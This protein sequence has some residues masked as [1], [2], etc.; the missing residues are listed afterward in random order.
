MQRIKWGL[1]TSGLNGTYLAMMGMDTPEDRAGIPN[2]PVRVCGLLMRNLLGYPQAGKL[3]AR[4]RQLRQDLQEGVTACHSMRCRG[5]ARG[6]GTQ[7]LAARCRGAERGHQPSSC[8]LSICEKEGLGDWP[9]NRDPLTLF[10]CLSAA[11]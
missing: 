4:A 11:C 7:S 2:V 6:R 1:A 10:T 5:P 3:L 9:S 8:D